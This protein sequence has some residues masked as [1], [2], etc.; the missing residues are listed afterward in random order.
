MTLNMIALKRHF[1]F[2]GVVLNDPGP[3]F[4]VEDI[5]DTYSVVYPDISTA[6]VETTT[7]ADSITYKFIRSVGTKG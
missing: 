5:R 3:E 7:G 4:S 6:V 1:T 2:N